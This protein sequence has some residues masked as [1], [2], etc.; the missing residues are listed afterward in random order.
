[1]NQA[2]ERP[3]LEQMQAWSDQLDKFLE[4]PPFAKRNIGAEELANKLIGYLPGT[5]DYARKLEDDND[6]L[7]GYIQECV[8]KFGKDAMPYD[9]TDTGLMSAMNPEGDGE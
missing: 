4:H 5:L 3:T 2:T 9:A 7:R 8:D 6:R 1:M